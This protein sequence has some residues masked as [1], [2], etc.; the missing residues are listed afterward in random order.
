MSE[1]GKKAAYSPDE[2]FQRANQL[3]EEGRVEGMYWLAQAYATGTGTEKDLEEAITWAD[4][5]AMKGYVKAYTLLAKLLV[6]RERREAG[7]VDYAEA[8]Y[9]AKK[10]IANGDASL[11]SVLESM[12]KL[13]SRQLQ[14]L[15][16]GS[17]FL[18]GLYP[19]S[20]EE[21]FGYITWRVLCV[22]DDRILLL[23]EDILDYVSFDEREYLTEEELDSPNFRHEMLFDHLWPEA[24][25][26]QW[27][28]NEFWNTAFGQADTSR[29]LKTRVH[30][31]VHPDHDCMARGLDR[32]A[33]MPEKINLR[34]V[35]SEDRIF[36]LSWE[37]AIAYL[38]D[39]REPSVQST[40]FAKG[41]RSC[42]RSELLWYNFEGS[43]TAAAITEY[44]VEKLRQKEHM[45]SDESYET[46]GTGD[47][48]LRNISRNGD[49]LYVYGG[50][51]G[52]TNALIYINSEMGR[53][54]AEFEKPGPGSIRTQGGRGRA[55]IRPA[56]W[57]SRK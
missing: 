45:V 47:W 23:S 51:D 36:L 32:G 31:T 49:T 48:W 27:L 19:M 46:Y 33:E 34:D 5:A 25:V 50:D 14:E 35:D 1:Q 39:G 13:Y 10:A 18:F 56:I 55:G 40:G 44:A 24:T 52:F 28:H 30:T 42:D 21:D 3:V 37:E 38:A 9:W 54:K 41:R 57:I 11:T 29:I 8:I 17:E 26:R 7:I 4:A 20:K 2:I 16:V 15:E 6:Q 12:E 22:E 43:E 53:Y